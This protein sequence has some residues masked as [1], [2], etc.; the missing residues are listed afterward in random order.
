[1]DSLLLE[2]ELEASAAEEY[3]L[4]DDATLPTI[5]CCVC[6]I[7]IEPNP[8]SMCLSCLKSQVNIT[9]SVPKQNQVQWCRFC[10]RYLQPPN[11]WLE[12][13]LES[14]ELLAICLKRIKG[15]GGRDEPRCVLL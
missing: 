7:S 11:A 1:M 5:I 8:T 4:F 14:R 9:E 15:F 12:A 10:G 13:E 2:S 6:G 3:Q